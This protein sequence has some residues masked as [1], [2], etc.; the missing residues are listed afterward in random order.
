[1]V[2]AVSYKLLFLGHRSLVKNITQTAVMKIAFQS[3]LNQNL[4]FRMLVN[5]HF[6]KW[7]LQIRE[8]YI[9]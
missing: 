1:M 2:H 9:S 3:I 5:I 6:Q 4:T 8:N 7:P